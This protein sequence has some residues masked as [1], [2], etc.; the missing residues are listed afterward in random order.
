M[1]GRRRRIVIVTPW[2]PNARNPTA[3]IFVE[4][5]ARALSRRHEVAVIAPEYRGW[6]SVRELGLTPTHEESDTPFPVLRPLVVGLIPRSVLATSLWYSAAVRRALNHLS[7]SWGAPELL[8]A[9]VVVPA[10][11]ATASA[12]RQFGLPFV[13]TEHWSR[14]PELLRWPSTRYLVRSTLRSASRVIAVSPM[15]ADHVQE[16]LQTVSVAVIGN[17]IDTSFYDQV[18]VPERS[19]GRAIR[20]L[21]IGLR[22]AR[23][24]M[25]DLLDAVQLAQRKGTPVQLVVVGDGPLRAELQHHARA[26]GIAGVCAFDGLRDRD[27]VRDRL[28]WCDALVVPSHCET[29]GVTVAEALASGRPVIATRC[30]GPE[31]V[32]D[33]AC[34]RLVPVRD[35]NTL[36]EAIVDLA[37]G[38]IEFDPKFA[39][40]SVRR[41]FGVEAIVDRLS[42]VYDEALT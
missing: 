16:A 40:A 37:A 4:E 35:P 21:S 25:H 8:H 10:G 38:R 24:G 36:A 33:E 19:E 11:C 42:E 14:F 12:A 27:G 20:L 28:R 31:F 41:R 5:Q 9:H 17:V 29:F 18:A 3:G 34:G 2:Y 32:M 30:G 26:L 1:T 15:L 23:K 22:D 7:R 39:R 13:L 6:R